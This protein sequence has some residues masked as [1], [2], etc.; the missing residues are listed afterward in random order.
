MK[1]Q[2]VNV[3]SVIGDVDKELRRELTDTDYFIV[4]GVVSNI[5]ADN[6]TV[7]DVPNRLVLPDR[8]LELS[9]YRDDGSLRD[10]DVLILKKISTNH[11]KYI[12]KV[13]LESIDG[14]L[15]PSVFGLNEYNPNRNRFK[16]N[17]LDWVSKR[18]IDENGVLSYELFPLSQRVDRKSYEPWHFQTKPSQ[19]MLPM[20]HPVG[21]LTAYSIRSISGLRPKDQQ[22]VDRMR[23]NL[24]DAA[25][26]LF[27]NLEESG[28]SGWLEFSD[29]LK[30]LIES[31][32]PIKGIK[33]GDFIAFKAKS[34]LLNFVE[35]NPRMVTLSYNKFIAKLLNLIIHS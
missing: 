35:S 31:P 3:Y 16:A 12:E 10:I 20:L 14:L 9:N 17:L 15:V 24:Y 23:Q 29:S 4:G 8:S 19:P 34:K 18:T 33:H 26:E 21:H 5:L 6:R 7:Y 32:R 1:K 30:E 25:P 22:K 28:L 11:L 27:E 13:V 2:E